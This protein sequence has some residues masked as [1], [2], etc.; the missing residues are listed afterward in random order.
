VFSVRSGNDVIAVSFEGAATGA[1]GF[2]AITVLVVLFLACA[3][4]LTMRRIAL[5][6]GLCYTLVVLRLMLAFVTASLLGPT[7]AGG[8]LGPGA[9]CATLGLLLVGI[10]IV[11][12]RSA[13][14]QDTHPARPP[15]RRNPV[16]RTRLALT[17][18]LVTGASIAALGMSGVARSSYPRI[19]LGAELTSDTPTRADMSARGSAG[20]S[21]SGGPDSRAMSGVQPESGR[22]LRPSLSRV[23][24]TGFTLDAAEVPVVLDLLTV[25]EPIS[26]T[27][28]NAVI[29]EDCYGLLPAGLPTPTDL[30]TDVY[31]LHRWWVDATGDRF[32]L[33]TWLE[34]GHST[35]WVTLLSPASNDRSAPIPEARFGPCADA[36]GSGTGAAGTVPAGVATRLHHA[37]A[38]QIS[39]DATESR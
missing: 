8:V 34:P 25:P 27:A 12:A 22:Q 26:P 15:T 39:A 32:Q 35:L 11:T 19:A 23:P 7:A 1:A 18:L 13:A 38:V 29:V 10:G 21:G 4:R 20:G 28:L 16:M 9:D 3:F 31:G 30:G 14:L 2:L 24:L 37:L 6:W 5:V 17:V 36:S 33:L